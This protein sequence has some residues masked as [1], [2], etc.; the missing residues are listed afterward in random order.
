MFF[1]HYATKSLEIPGH[2]NTL[3]EWDLQDLS[4]GVLQVWPI[5]KSLVGKPKKQICSRL[6][7]TDHGG[8]KNH[9][10]KTTMVLF[11]NVFY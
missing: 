1:F 4:N 3:Q 5:S 9:D 11:R 6:A 7:T 8:Q 2:V 10:E